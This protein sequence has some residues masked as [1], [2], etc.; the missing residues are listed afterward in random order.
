MNKIQR[1]KIVLLGD[2][3]SGKSTFVSRIRHNV[4]S[5]HINTTN[6]DFFSKTYDVPGNLNKIK[7][8]I[9]DTSG[10]EIF[11]QFTRQFIRNTD[12]VLLFFDINT[13]KDKNELKSYINDW[14]HYIN[15][16]KCIVILVPSKT[17]IYIGKYKQFY[18][19]IIGHFYQEIHIAEPISSKTNHR[20]EELENQIIR[21]VE[22]IKNNSV[23]LDYNSP[24]TPRKCYST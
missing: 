6:C 9:W 8:L 18:Y 24:Q 5:E 15:D 4:F 3:N 2:N 17:D 12:V 22:P 13:V 19:E 16:K 1:F 21:I 7:L 10:K 11:K 23:D 14:L 20:I